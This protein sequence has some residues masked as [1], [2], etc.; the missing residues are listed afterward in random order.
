MFLKLD[1]HY[2]KKRILEILRDPLV[3]GRIWR[4]VGSLRRP[5]RTGRH[6][7]DDRAQNRA[8]RNQGSPTRTGRHASGDCAQDRAEIRKGSPARTGRHTAGGRAQGRADRRK[9][10]PANRPARSRRPG[11]RTELTK[12]KRDKT[13]RLRQSIRNRHGGSCER[14]NI[15]YTESSQI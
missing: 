10:S 11:N 4:R 2:E 3:I 9:G 6:A 13:D 14:R 8:E 5:T 12:R 1:V 15:H 7:S